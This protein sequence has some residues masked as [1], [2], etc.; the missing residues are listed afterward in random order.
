MKKGI[1]LAGGAGTRLY[2]LT[3][4]TNKHL[5]PIYDKQ[6]ILYP[7]DTLKKCGCTSIMIVLSKLNMEEI[8]KLVGNDPDVSVFFVY[9]DNNK[10][11]IANALSL[12]KDFINNEKFI[13][14]LGDNIILNE[15]INIII[16]DFF[17]NDNK[18][19]EIFIKKVENPDQFGI[20]IINNNNQIIDIIEKPKEYISN[21][22]VIG[23]Y[24][25]DSSV[26]DIINNLHPSSRGEYEITDVNDEYIKQNK[27]T[28]NILN[29]DVI[30]LDA[31]TYKSLNEANNL[32]YN[33]H[34]K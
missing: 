29:D 15:N 24:M 10:G 28:Y 19:A 18:V 21:N 33:L 12:C 20:A 25:Y 26:F 6:M 2:P 9:Q 31:G 7:F 11:G 30:W 14:I 1:I 4:T 22:A 17:N 3:S 32:I 5:L 13:L 34:N 27:L 23:L 16:N 8:I